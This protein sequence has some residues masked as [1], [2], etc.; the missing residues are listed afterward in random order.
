MVK[1]KLDFVNDKEK[2]FDILRE[3]PTAKTCH[4]EASFSYSFKLEDGSTL[5]IGQSDDDVSEPHFCFFHWW[6]KD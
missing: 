3:I 5:Q 1:S 2:L 4:G 6:K